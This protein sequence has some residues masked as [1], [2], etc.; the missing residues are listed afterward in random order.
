MSVIF[1]ES[2]VDQEPYSSPTL[3]S[4]EL[5]KSEHRSKVWNFFGSQDQQKCSWVVRRLILCDC[6]TLPTKTFWCHTLKVLWT[7]NFYT[8]VMWAGGLT[9]ASSPFWISLWKTNSW[10]GPQGTP[11]ILAVLDHLRPARNIEDGRISGIQPKEVGSR[12]PFLPEG[13][14]QTVCI[15][16]PCH[17]MHGS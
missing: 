9:L 12:S 11:Q 8:E 1:H 15:G 6:H 13:S 4:L 3:S 17:K 5:R 2:L 10:L 14:H 7:P 16:A